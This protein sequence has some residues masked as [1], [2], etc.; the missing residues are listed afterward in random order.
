MAASFRPGQPYL[1]DMRG[2][3]VDERI[4]LGIVTRGSLAERLLRSNERRLARTSKAIVVLSEVAKAEAVARYD[5]DPDK[6]VVIPT[7][8]DLDLFKLSPSAPGPVCVLLSGTFSARYDVAAMGRFIRALGERTQVVAR[9]VSPDP[10][11]S[12]ELARCGVDH[13]ASSATP[14]EMPG[15]VARAHVGICFQ[16]PDPLT[17][18]NSVPTKI[19]EFL[20]TGR[21]VVVSPKLGDM[22]TIL[23]RYHCGVVVD[24]FEEEALGRAAYALLELLSDD[25]VQERCLQAAEENFSLTDAIVRLQRTYRS[26][27]EVSAGAR[28]RQRSRR[29][30]PAR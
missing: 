24:D 4:A 27:A 10:A 17:A 30:S 6:V 2:F 8:V 21:P 23:E 15:A 9:V 11:V 13:E 29:G 5:I 26:I 16:R 20:A 28:R 25:D 7:C 22:D 3:W 1:W 14:D 19:A 18:A 12:E